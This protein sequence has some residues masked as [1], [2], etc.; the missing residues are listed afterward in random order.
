MRRLLFCLEEL[1]RHLREHQGVVVLAVST[2]AVAFFLLGLFL[3]VWVNLRDMVQVASDEARMEVFLKDGLDQ[4]R[5]DAIRAQLEREESV[6]SVAYVSADDALTR[7]KARLKDQAVLLEGLDSNPLPASFEVRLRQGP[8]VLAGLAS[9][10]DRIQTWDGVDA[11]RYGREWVDR[12]RVFWA[13]VKALGVG[14][15]VL[16]AIAVVAIVTNTIRFL[17]GARGIDIMVMR[18][19]GAS[20][21]LIALPYLLEGIL[22]GL[23]SVA[24]AIGLLAALVAQFGPSLEVIGGFLLGRGG[25]HFLSPDLLLLWLAA[26]VVLGGAGSLIALRRYFRWAAG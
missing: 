23:V 18:I 15:G 25:L 5:R 2:M 17:I 14:L 21:A 13:F 26:G 1:G 19:V 16:V 7:F 12:F 8:A 22:L 3:L 6:Q 10:A 4:S 24:G 11:V 20:P 9:L